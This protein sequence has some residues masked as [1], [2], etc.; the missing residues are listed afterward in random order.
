MDKNNAVI[1]EIFRMTPEG[2]RTKFEAV[3]NKSLVRD[4]KNTSYFA[5]NVTD[6]AHD[7]ARDIKIS[8]K[9][10]IV[11]VNIKFPRNTYRICCEMPFVEFYT[12]VSEGGN[13]C[14]LG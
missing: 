13:K 11:D 12:P 9:N 3:C 2:V 10:K 4:K 8:Q 14:I 5:M 6:L 7:L 1:I